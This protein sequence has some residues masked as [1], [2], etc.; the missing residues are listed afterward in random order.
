MA[1]S[2]D[3]AASKWR[4]ADMAIKII[5]VNVIIFLAI[6]IL[7]IVLMFTGTSIDSVLRW[8]MVPPSFLALAHV[9]WTLLTYMFCH[10]EVLHILFNMLW[11][12]WFGRMFMLVA[13]PKQLF[14]LYIYGGIA[15]AAMYIGLCHLSPWI[16]GSGLIGASASIM[17]LVIATAVITPDIPVSLLFIGEIKL[18][19]LAVVT[20]IL[21]ALGLTGNNAGG[22]AAHLGGATMGALYGLAFR[23]GNDLAKPFNRLVDAIVSLLSVGHPRT[24]RT[25]RYHYRPSDRR[26][27]VSSSSGHIDIDPILEKIKKSGYASLS[28]DEK[29][30]LFE[31]SSRMK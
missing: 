8:V 31:A 22:H 25:K 10:Y 9:P 21:F 3:W 15:G 27:G 19:W 26:D 20:V 23:R 12:Y 24:L 5:A 7:A 14:A 6:R 30:K 29:R 2:I 17:A 4:Q 16:G 18:K 13:T 11:L 28:A 1:V